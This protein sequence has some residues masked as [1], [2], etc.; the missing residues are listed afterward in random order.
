MKQYFVLFICV[1]IV[2]TFTSDL[3]SI[4]LYYHLVYLIYHSGGSRNFKTGCGGRSRRGRIF[5]SGF[6]FDAPSHIPFVFVAR[7][8][9]K[10]HNLN[11]VYWLKSKYMR[12]IQSKFTKKQT[13]KRACPGSAFVPC[14]M[15]F[16]RINEPWTFAIP[17]PITSLGKKHMKKW[18]KGKIPFWY[19]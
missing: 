6:C 19:M 15:W 13:R 2:F 4:Q 8:V 10:I 16:E 11:I 5:R 7:V 18:R 1:L 3:V 12:I 17:S 9:N 14:Q